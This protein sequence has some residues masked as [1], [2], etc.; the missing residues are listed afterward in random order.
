MSVSIDKAAVLEPWYVQAT[1]SAVR[2]TLLCA[3]VGLLLWLVVRQ[4][5][6]RE[7]A[8]ERLRV[9]T[10]QLDE[11]FESAPEA[12][13][14]LD[15]DGRVTRI[16]REF[17][18][19]FGYTSREAEGGVLDELIVPED[20]K[21]ES[22]L[23]ADTVRRGQH[24]STE[25]ERS[26]KDG[27]RRHVS[28][29]GAP[30]VTASGPIASYSIYRDMTERKLAEAERLKLEMRLR[31]A[32]KLEAIGTMAGG[33]AHDFN[34]ILAAMIGYANM[35]LS[36]AVDG[37]MVKR[38][39]GNVLA[40]ADRA[41]ALVDQ[42]LT[43]SPSTRAKRG[44]VHVAALIQEALELVRAALPANVELRANL[45][46]REATV[47]ADATQVHQ[48]VMNLCNNAVQAMGAGGELNVTLDAV[49]TPADTALS[50]SLLA[51]GRY[52]HLAVRDSG[53]G[54]DAAIVPHIFAPFFTTKESGLGTGLG[55]ALVHGIVT[56]LGGAI[57]V[58]TR[59]GKGST[60]DLY[61]PRSDAPH[62]G[63]ADEKTPLLRGNGEH[64][65]LIED[66]QAQMLL[67]EEMLAALNYEPSGF[68]RVADALGEFRADP[69]RFDA[70]F[71]D[72]LLPGITGI[73]LA[74]N[75]RAA[76]SDIPIVMISGYTGPVLAR[77]ALAVGVD[78]ILTKPLDFRQLAEAM[79]K[80]LKRAIAR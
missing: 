48:L 63:I 80:A 57:N 40:T 36:A 60:F 6:R 14:M 23:I 17:T 76:R 11:L 7:L 49:T 22:K 54:M 29:L 78:Q 69:F 64:V 56:E 43:Y 1:H 72:Y 19:L 13:V 66:E 62:L 16:N 71:L 3:S 42:I 18:R 26:H 8:E 46:A 21:W 44:V 52:V 73:E 2:T 77:E 68:T 35:G 4:L 59:P 70:V 45:N 24:P 75:L 34:S 15:L 74:R 31:H 25:T 33:I 47:I 79:A 55:L 12:I 20:L 39:I 28:A 30:I 53:S 32:E 27:S 67:A 41:R 51:A 58:S 9:Q 37:S 65:L 61:L 5:R 38:H 10:A 50:H